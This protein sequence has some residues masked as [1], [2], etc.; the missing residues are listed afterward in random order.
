MNKLPSPSNGWF[1]Q[2]P[3]GIL[4][5]FQ[6]S[7]MASKLLTFLLGRT[8][9][10]W[11]SL[12]VLPIPYYQKSA[13]HSIIKEVQRASHFRIPGADLFTECT[14][15]L[16]ILNHTFSISTQ[17]SQ[18]LFQYHSLR[19]LLLWL[20]F[21]FLFPPELSYFASA[22]TPL[23]SSLQSSRHRFRELPLLFWRAMCIVLGFIYLSC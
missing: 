10:C 6:E 18:R 19:K 2:R 15:C 4:A 16:L 8:N 13:Q 12:Q 7:D 1:I 17:I 5:N 14:S 3:S 11:D 9:V 21:L 20:H 22:S 23:S